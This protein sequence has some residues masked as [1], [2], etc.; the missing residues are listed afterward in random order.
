M[1][2]FNLGYREDG[3]CITSTLTTTKKE[4][5]SK[6]ITFLE[7]FRDLMPQGNRIAPNPKTSLPRT[8]RIQIGSPIAEHWG[9]R[10]RVP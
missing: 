2:H 5:G 10:Y 6:I 7:R 1:F 3:K 9:K 8:E 4:I